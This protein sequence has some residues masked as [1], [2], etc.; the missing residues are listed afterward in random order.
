[1]PDLSIIIVSYNTRELTLACLHSVY[2]QTKD[3]TFEVIVVD[4]ASADG[5][6][7]A[8]EAYFPKVSLIKSE[9]NLGFAKANNIAARKAIGKYLLLLNPDTVILNG[10]I[11][12]L[13][14]FAESNPENGIYGGRTLFAD[15]S[16]NHAS[17]W[18]KPTLWSLFCYGVGLTSMFRRSNLFDHEA[19][20]SWPRDS[21]REVDIVSGC[22]FLIERALWEKLYGFDPA[23]FMY[24]EEADLCLRAIKVGAKPV[25][26]PASTII[27]YGGVSEKIKADKAVR[28]FKAKSMLIKRHW[29]PMLAI[30]GITMYKLAVFLRSA[31]CSVLY[32]LGIEK[33]K[34]RSNTW[35]EVWFRRLEW[36]V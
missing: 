18:K 2:E 9:I 24:A 27:H 22:F 35:R 30:Y 12:K 36:R 14:S 25:V 29:Q 33:F 11:Q 10:A 8:I 20:G 32:S 1:M 6:A 31:I 28:L 4:N 7:E 5:S 17:C 15:G 21:V 19:Y 13:F 26:T 23:F 3:I 34:E 16:L